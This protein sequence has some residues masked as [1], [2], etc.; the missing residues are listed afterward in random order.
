MNI[1][2]TLDSNYI[3]PLCVMLHSLAQTNPNGQFDIYVAYSSL[4][5][6]D[7]E[8]MEKALGGIDATIHKI[9]VDNSIFS[10][11]PVLDRLSKETYY[12]LLIGDIL[13][14]DVHRILYLDPDLVVNRDITDFYNLD[15]QGKTLAGC[16]HMFGFFDKFN[17][18][19]LR[20]K[21]KNRYIN[22]GVLLIDLDKWRETVTV[23]QI[24]D[25]ISANIKRLWLADQDVINY[26]FCSSILHIDERLYNL[27]EKTLH[28]YTSKYAVV[29]RTKR[30]HID[31]LDW[32][33]KN[34]YIIHFNGKH[35]PWREGS[36]Y[37]GKLG[38]FF[39]KYKSL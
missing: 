37:K 15:L 30:M 19:R 1:L 13:P 38:E 25:Y 8:N 26:I 10:G 24:L 2:V 28:K 31:S 34:T 29:K 7:F 11:A 16:M 36:E 33:R 5:D 14:A 22:A 20:V 17:L 3:Y 4:T 27:D 35:K 18:F 9:L 6:E 21:F 32:V 12:R 39:E 23:P